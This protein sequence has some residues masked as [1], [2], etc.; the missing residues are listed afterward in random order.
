MHEIAGATQSVKAPPRRAHML[1]MHPHLSGII[2]KRPFV[3]QLAGDAPHY[4][5]WLA[6]VFSQ[7]KPGAGVW[8]GWVWTGF[9]SSCKSSRSQAD[10]SGGS[11]TQPEQSR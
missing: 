7:W 6:R 1:E 10:R 11:A 2:L 8:R 4:F 3:V 5:D 9:Q